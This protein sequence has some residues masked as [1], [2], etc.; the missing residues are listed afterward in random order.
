MAAFNPCAVIPVYNHEHQLPRVVAD[1]LGLVPV[2]LVNDG[3]G[4]RCTEVVDSLARNHPDVTV[5]SRQCNAGKG[6][7]VKLG[8]HQA[9][10]MGYSHALQIDADGQHDTQDAQ[11]FL[12]L[13]KAHPDALIAGFPIYDRSVP[14]IRFLGHYL[15]NFWVSVNTLSFN[16]QDAMC[17]FRVYPLKFSCELVSAAHVG[18]R[19]EFD[20]EFL[21]RWLWA[22]QPIVQVG[23]KVTYPEGGVSHF[24]A[25]RDNK[26]ISWMHT[27][28][29][30]GM[31]AR[32]PRIVHHKMNSHA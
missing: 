32:L 20:P 6:A 19:M 10:A 12:D 14:W 1:L 23:T 13:A 26:R 11:K 4:P 25:W 30:F 15:T 8:F 7:A 18:N 5:A 22:F 29:F 16:I 24:D 9:A 27:R 17:G 28:H 31:L 2:L 21:V 3:S